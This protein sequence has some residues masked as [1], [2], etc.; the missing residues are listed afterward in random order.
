MPTNPSSA[1]TA[2]SNKIRPSSAAANLQSH[3]TYN[4]LLFDNIGCPST[5]AVR[6][7]DLSLLSPRPATQASGPRKSW[8]LRTANDA[9]NHTEEHI[10]HPRRLT[11]GA[12]DGIGEKDSIVRPGLIQGTVAEKLK[13]KIE[14]KINIDTLEELKKAFLTADVNQTGC[15]ELDEFKQLLK[16]QL[17]L[18]QTKLQQID[19][20]FMKIDWS[21]E[22]A[23]TWDEFCTYM[24]LE[25]AEKEDSYLR[26]KEVAFQLPAKIENLPHRDPILRITD[27]PDGTF[28]ACSQDGIVSF[29]SANCELKRTRSVVNNEQN[30]R[31]KSKWIT[32]FCIMPHFN[33][34]IVGTGDREIQFFELSSFEPYCQI[35]GLETV[36]LNLDYSSTG[37]DESLILYGDSQG[38]INILVIKSTGECLRTWKKMPKHDA[39]I[40]SISLDSVASSPNVRFI[41]WQVHGDWVQQLKYYHDIG[42]VISCSNH[43]NTALVIG[44]TSGSTHVEQQLKELKDVNA[45]ERNKQKGFYAYNTTKGRLEADQSVFK[46]YKGVKCFDFSKEKNIIVTGGMDRIIR[47]WNPYVF[48]KPT[49]ML[50]GHNAPIFYLF[51]G[52]EDNRMYSISTDKCIKVWDIQDQNCLVTIRPKS[53]KIR[54]D[55]QAIHYSHVSKALSVATDQMAMLALRLSAVLHADIVITHKEPITCC[56]YNSSFKQ[57]VTCSEGSVIKLWDLNTGT[58]IFEYGEAHGDNAI[59]CMTFDNTGRR[60]ITG[61]RDGRLKVWNYNNGHCLKVFQKESGNEEICDVTYIEINRNRYVIS[62]GWDKRV[63]I[64]CDSQSDSNIHHVQHPLPYWSDDVKNGHKED[65]LSVAQC[66]PNLLATA[67]YDGE[68]IV[69]NMVSGHIFCHLIPPPPKHYTDQS[70]DGD[71]NINTIV[72]LPTRA[73]EKESATLVASGPRANIHFWNVFQGGKLMAQFSGSKLNGA[74]VSTMIVNQSN[75]KLYSGDSLGFIYVWNIKN[76]CLIGL[77]SQPPELLYSWRGHVEGVNGIDLVEEQNVLLTASSDCT[78]RLWTLEGHYIGT[79]GQPDSWDLYNPSTFQHPMVPYDVLIDPISLPA[80]PILTAKETTHQIIHEDSVAD[81]QE[82]VKE[83]TPIIYG[84]QQFFVSDETIASQLKDKIYKKGTGKRLRHEIMKP[85]KIDRGGPSEY[86][87]LKCYDLKDTP[88]INPPSLKVNKE[89]PFAFYID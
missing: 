13:F 33:K 9:S 64:Y 23:I 44:C 47:M 42:Q 12:V 88:P 56:K 22:G 50:R 15:L 28:I 20:L 2:I 55:L 87:M 86:Q 54:G 34:I 83:T 72:F 70:L 7:T 24:Q 57:V 5:A 36:P 35:S 43:A 19:A 52:E 82:E 18:S 4:T 6:G 14:E 37:Y 3:P 74:M 27:T 8:K 77:E 84:R 63:N 26:A 80:H 75:S 53:H 65:I 41:R 38:C 45:Q 32:D 40:A 67:G 11:L 1:G 81:V 79:L 16:C 51:I 17:H 46:V 68:V 60:L 49:G 76:Y 69:W 89:N 30:N 25:Y 48:G 39:F 59:T 66:T 58:A 31:Q 21:S 10:R 61:G 62:V 71:L 73:Y 85:V 78:V 29:W